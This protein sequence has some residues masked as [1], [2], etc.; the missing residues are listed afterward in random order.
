MQP[1]FSATETVWRSEQDSNPQYSFQC[2]SKTR[3]VIELL[4][5]RLKQCTPERRNG[6]VQTAGGPVSAAGQKA[7]AWRFIGREGRSRKP[8]TLKRVRNLTAR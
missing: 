2:A 5:F 8:S 1:N 7:K 6:L 3:C 4:G